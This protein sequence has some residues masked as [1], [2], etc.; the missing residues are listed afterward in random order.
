LFG[1]GSLYYIAAGA[2]ILSAKLIEVQLGTQK[3]Q[4]TVTNR[5]QQLSNINKEEQGKILISQLWEQSSKAQADC[6]K[7]LQSYRDLHN[8]TIDGNV[9][10]FAKYVTLATDL[11][12]EKESFTTTANGIITQFQ[13]TPY[14]IDVCNT[15]Y[16]NLDEAVTA[17]NVRMS[18]L[19]SQNVVPGEGYSPTCTGWSNQT[20][21]EKAECFWY[22]SRCH[23]EPNCWIPN[24]I[25]GC[26]LSAGVGTLI[27]GTIVLIGIGG[28]AYWLL[29]R[30]PAE[31]RTII[32]S[33]R[34]AV[35]GE[36]EKAKQAY[37]RIAPLP[38]P[39][40][41]PALLIRPVQKPLLLPLAPT[42]T[43]I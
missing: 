15:F 16:S 7:R 18:T 3:L 25:G 43:R 41:K 19:I 4:N 39:V 5:G 28:A 8:G 42:S 24:P 33:A 13:G 26:I 22:N 6:L 34:G 17:S 36:V 40:P 35:T 27:V 1:I 9:N 30:H 31:T 11:K 37:R 14:T 29:T 23:K 21:C 38:P 12:S 20:D 2:I 10:I 32:T